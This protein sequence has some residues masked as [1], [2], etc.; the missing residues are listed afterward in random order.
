MSIYDTLFSWRAEMP[1]LFERLATHYGLSA[2]EDF[3]YDVGEVQ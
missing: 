3:A 1:E 2:P